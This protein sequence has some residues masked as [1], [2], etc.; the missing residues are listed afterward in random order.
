MP[1]LRGHLLPIYVLADESGSM[2]ELV[3]ELNAGLVSLHA[4]LLAEPMAAAKVRM[5]VIGFSDTAELRMHLT[6]LRCETHLPQLVCRTATSYGAAFEALARQIPADVERLKAQ[7]YAVHR[8]AVFFLSDGQPSDGST[9]QYVHRRLVDRQLTV[10]APNII[11]C[12][13]GDAEPH[14]IL[15]VAT[16]PEYAYVSIAGADVGQAIARFCAALTKSVIASGRSLGNG[17]AELSV[18][19]PEGFRMA[20]DVV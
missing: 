5:S 9:W 14:T 4:A 20:I 16:R 15:E 6:D 17:S 10:G 19:Q 2:T 12:G 11:A 3:G 7:Q 18:S 13:I 1:D 8:P